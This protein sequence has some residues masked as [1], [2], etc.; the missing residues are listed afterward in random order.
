MITQILDCSHLCL[1]FQQTSVLKLRA[2]WYS[3][4]KAKPLSV[5]VNTNC[6]S[7]GRAF[8]RRRPYFED[9]LGSGSVK[10]TCQHQCLVTVQLP[11]DLHHFMVFFCRNQQS[12]AN[13]SLRHINH[14]SQFRGNILVLKVSIVNKKT[15]VNMWAGDSVLSDFLVAQ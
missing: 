12:P 4:V 6:E 10:P 15:V 7:L 3:P 9:Y 13:Q 2:R 8:S 11:H 1:F 5:G 14:S